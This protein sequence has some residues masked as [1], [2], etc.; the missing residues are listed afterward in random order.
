MGWINQGQLRKPLLKTPAALNQEAKSCAAHIDDAGFPFC[1]KEL[2]EDE[3]PQ[4]PVDEVKIRN[5]AE[6][7]RLWIVVDNIVYDC[8]LWANQHPGGEDLIKHF[9]GQECSW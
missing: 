2:T 7:A 3:L 6:A 8:T 9:G 4:I 5:G 1:S